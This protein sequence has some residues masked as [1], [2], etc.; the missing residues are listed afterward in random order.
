MNQPSPTLK[1]LGVLLFPE[2]E[3]LDVFGPLQ[4]FGMLP[5]QINIVLVAEQHGLVKSNQGQAVYA[6]FNWQNAPHLDYLLVPG[7]K[8]TRKEVNNQQLLHWIKSRSVSAELTLSVCT[9]AALLAKAGVLNNHKATTNKLAFEWVAE[10]GSQV[11][12]IK[13]ARWCASSN[14]TSTGNSRVSFSSQK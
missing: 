6:E 14:S 7:G 10:Q 12:W 5:E 13:K 1:T 3:T 11:S 9:G 8:G 4:M 2:F